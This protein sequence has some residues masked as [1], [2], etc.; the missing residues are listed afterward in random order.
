MCDETL[1]KSEAE[2]ERCTAIRGLVRGGDLTWERP[3][4]SRG[5]DKVGTS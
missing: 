1:R 3:S 5:A 2:K 4:G